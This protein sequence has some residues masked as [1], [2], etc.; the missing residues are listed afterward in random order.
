VSRIRRYNILLCLTFCGCSLLARESERAPSDRPVS[1][2]P[3]ITARLQTQV[4]Q[5]I[6]P[7]I[8]RQE[9]SVIEAL[10]GA[11]FAP[12]GFKRPLAL[13]ALTDP[14]AGFTVLESQSRQT[15]DLA[16][17]LG[18]WLPA[19][20]D[21]LEVAMNRS[22]DVI[23]PL[24][25]P[26]NGTADDQ[27]AFLVSLLEQARR[28]QHEA[29]Q[30]LSRDDQQFLFDHAAFMVEQFSP[31]LS[32]ENGQEMAAAKSNLYFIRIVEE[33]LRYG[34]LLAEAKLVAQLDN[35]PW[36]EQVETVFRRLPMSATRLNGVT[37]DLLL[38]QETPS[39]LLVIGGPGPNRYDLDQRF[40]MVIDVGGDDT[41]YGM[42]AAPGD[43]DHGIGIVIDFSG[44][45]IYHASPLGLATGRL[46]VGLLVDGNGDDVYHLAEGSGGTGFA[47]VGMLH[48][49]KGNDRYVGS[50]FTQGAAV[51]GLGVLIDEEGHDIHTSFGYAIGFGGPLGVG[52]VLDVS[53]DDSYQ[54]GD[55]YPSRYNT[56]DAPDGE[57]GDPR[58]QYDA[59]GIG[60]GVGTRIFS[61]NPEHLVYGLAGGVG[62][63]IDLEGNDRYR[64]SNFSQG[65]GYFFG[66]GVMLDLAGNDLHAGARYGHG[67]GAH[68]GV[69]LFIDARGHDHYLS[70]GPFYNG[71]VAWDL[72]VSLCI[73]A[74]DGDD[75][76]DLLRS[77]GL[78][79]A[80]HRS[81][82]LF[83]DEGGRDRYAVPRGLGAA[84][85]RSVSGFLDLA[86]DDEYFAPPASALAPRGNGLEWSDDNGSVFIDRKE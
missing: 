69:G 8:A 36:L 76:Y 74:E 53:G 10:G 71:G 49:K 80:D 14:W 20:I 67:A 19:I 3:S 27:V 37:G 11:R 84:T 6:T 55:V 4:R 54:C 12:A 85:D 9:R 70:S 18:Q 38:V 72:S 30:Q 51:G 2:S 48:D 52:T 5:A 26:T 40:A 50:R 29:V 42:I 46:G 32:G 41:Y 64:S 24:S 59:F 63:A 62:L 86:G 21:R 44:N 77:D 47:G 45:D 39:G 81:W 73:D 82:S 1:T 43:I 15:A 33:R 57:P 13:H 78:G 31:Q 25:F 16:G 61:R 22:A 68:Y 60:T 17:S 58:F 65:V 75:V 28:L 23:V 79:R 7:F 66:I 35:A 56:S 34:V 83:I